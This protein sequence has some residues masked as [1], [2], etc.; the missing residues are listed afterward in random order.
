MDGRRAQNF[1][2]LA[3]LSKYFFHNLFRDLEESTIAEVLQ[4]AQFFLRFVEE[5]DNQMLMYPISK[6]ELEAAFKGM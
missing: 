3:S 6:D 1:E 5:E 4:I 2:E